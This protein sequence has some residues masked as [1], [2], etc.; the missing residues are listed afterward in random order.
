MGTWGFLT[1]HAHVLIQIARSPRSTGREISLAVGITERAAINVLHDLRGAGIVSTRREGRRNVHHVNVVALA[2]HR[3]WAAP[4]VE[5]PQALI[6]AALRGLGQVAADSAVVNGPAPPSSDAKRRWSFLTT[7][8]L[9]LIYVTQHPHS[10]V[11]EISLAIGVTERAAHAVLRD[12]REAGIIE[13]ERD[14][15]RNSYTVSFYYLSSF[16][17]EGTAPDL[18]PDSFVS[19]LIDAL[20]PLQPPDYPALDD[21]AHPVD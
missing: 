19:A 16:R 6:E 8:A 5:V 7:H 13:C 3:P 2:Q 18:V 1:N 12:L 20:R 21:S 10:T 9:C 4:G 14:G 11:R 17:R 15:R